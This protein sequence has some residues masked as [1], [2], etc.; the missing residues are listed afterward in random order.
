[1]DLVSASGAVGEASPLRGQR[2][3][4]KWRS[5]ADSALQGGSSSPNSSANCLT[6]EEGLT[7]GNAPGPAIG[8]YGYMLVAFCKRLGFISKH[9]SPRNGGSQQQRNKGQL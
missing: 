1:M 3:F 8:N 4:V 9:P 6:V 7:P 5:H 2:E